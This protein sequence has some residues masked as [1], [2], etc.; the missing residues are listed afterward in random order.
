MELHLRQQSNFDLK[1]VNYYVTSLWGVFL[2]EARLGAQLQ[3]RKTLLSRKHVLA[4]L[5]FGQMYGNW[6]IDDWKRV[7]FSDKTKINRFNFVARSWCLIGDE[8]WVGPQHVHQT[9]KHGGGSLMIWGCM[10]TFGLGAWYKIE[11][12]MDRHLYEFIVESFL[13]STIQHY[14]MDPSKLVFQHDDD[15]KHTSKIVQEWLVSQ[16]FQLLQWPAQS[17]DLNPIEHLWAFL[18]RH[19]QEVSNNCGSTCVQCILI[20]MNKITWRFTRACHKVLML[21]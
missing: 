18:K 7:I 20:S 10:T 15:P 12:R 3:Q 8:E 5:R 19:F 13:W 2:I 14:T 1:H 17:P 21:C 16:P 9:V 4:C 11:G 6:T